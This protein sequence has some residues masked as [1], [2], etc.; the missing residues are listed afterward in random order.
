M[1]YNL[2]NK[3]RISDNLLQV[4]RNDMKVNRTWGSGARGRKP[5]KSNSQKTKH[6]YI[7]SKCHWDF[8]L[9][10]CDLYVYRMAKKLSCLNDKINKYWP[11]YAI[12]RL[13]KNNMKTQYFFSFNI[14][15]SYYNLF[16]NP[17]NPFSFRKAVL[18]L[19]PGLKAANSKHFAKWIILPNCV[20]YSLEF[21]ELR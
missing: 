16:L 11:I 5:N 18:T 1:F 2:L 14:S 7:T 3:S 10:L 9:L 12:Q 17:L 15:E 6:W 4:W 8:I 20:R 19:T 21:P 13:S